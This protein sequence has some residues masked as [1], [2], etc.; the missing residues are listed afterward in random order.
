MAVEADSNLAES[1]QLLGNIAE[2]ERRWDEALNYYLKFLSL[3]P[4]NAEQMLPRVLVTARKTMQATPGD[5]S[6]PAD[7]AAWV[8][9]FER[10]DKR[11]SDGEELDKGMKRVMAIGAEAI[12][13]FDRAVEINRQIAAEDTSDE[14]SR[15]SLLRLYYATASTKR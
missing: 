10:L 8:T 4:D 5:D 14:F 11:I 7:S 3:R 1:Y 12:G 15:R 9:F 2:S 6:E 13:R